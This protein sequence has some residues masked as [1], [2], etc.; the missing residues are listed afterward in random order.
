MPPVPT[1]SDPMGG[2]LSI[3]INDVTIP[4]FMLG[5]ISPNVAPLLRTSERLSGT[6]T[7][8]TSQLDNPS[9][10]ITFFPN[11]WSDVGFFM[12]DNLDGTA[13]V[14][15]GASCTLPDAV[16][17]VLHYECEEDEDRDV[18]FEARVSF[19]D[20]SART[21]T[22]DLSVTIHFYPVGEITYGTPPTS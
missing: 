2:K 21:A 9:F 3:D 17:V 22:D 14:V 19:E 4:S 18:S 8:P 1:S 20:N 7:T 11:K 6:T 13:F 15:G 5:E 16:P 10:D 12:P